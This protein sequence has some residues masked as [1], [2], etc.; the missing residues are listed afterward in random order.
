MK[1]CG[2]DEAGRGPLAGP[3][4]VAGVVFNHN[5]YI[6]GVKDSK[7]ISPQ[8]RNKLYREIVSKCLFYKIEIVDNIEIDRIN[9]LRAT[10][11]GAEKILKYLNNE[12]VKVLMDGNYFKFE[13]DMHLNYDY[14]TVI[15]GDNKIFAISAASI[16]AK[17]ARDNIM[18]EYDSVYPLYK[19]GKNKGYPTKEHINLIKEHGI[20]AIHR[21]SFCEKFLN[22]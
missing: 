16:L 20:C 5:D 4:V 10:M 17:V 1:I 9:I 18:I 22:A 21:I 6:K 14:E 12:N 19:F 2:I 7:K 3:V 11:K 13:N 15:K 8:K